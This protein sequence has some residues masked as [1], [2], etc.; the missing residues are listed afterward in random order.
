MAITTTAKDLMI[1]A[2]MLYFDRFDK[3]GNPTGERPLG[4]ATDFI[5]TTATEKKEKYS[6]M[7]AAKGLLRSVVTKITITAKTK[8]D[9]FSPANL[10]LALMGEEGLY[11][12]AAK[13]GLVEDFAKVTQGMYYN[14]GYKN[15]KSVVVESIPTGT[16]YVA[17]VD[18]VLNAKTGR[19]EIMVGGGIADGSD[20]KVAFGADACVMTKISGGTVSRIEGYLHFVGDP[21]HGPAYEGEFWKVS[22]SPDGDLGFITEDWGSIGL[23]IEVQ[24]DS[25]NHPKDP[26]YRLLNA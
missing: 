3:E 20:I 6:T 25:E 12:Q 17:D 4:N 21:T 13:A 16:V 23:S 19:I 24:N 1:G 10:A 7:S 5:L 2:G 11:T 15:V 22:I 8:L 14:L 9:Y 26:Y 18:Y